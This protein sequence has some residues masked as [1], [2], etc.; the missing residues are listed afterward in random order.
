M[1][2]LGKINVNIFRPFSLVALFAVNEQKL[3]VKV[4]SGR[5]HK[6]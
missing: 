5:Y 6:P 4:T 2:H 1:L 3:S